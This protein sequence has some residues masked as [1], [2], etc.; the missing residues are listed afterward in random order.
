MNS[1]KMRKI[2]ALPSKD[3]LIERL[4]TQPVSSVANSYGVSDNAFRKWLQKYDIPHTKQ[5][6]REYAIN[7]GY[8]YEVRIKPSCNRVNGS[9]IASAK[10]SEADVVII[11]QLSVSGE[12]H[13]TIAKQFNVSKSTI[14]SI[15]N[16]RS[17][18]HVK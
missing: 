16:G 12:S 6:F 8:T 2:S 3:V 11:R 7:N 14:S 5:K 15:L 4:C 17:W 13:R 18:T 9:D 10:L 1:D